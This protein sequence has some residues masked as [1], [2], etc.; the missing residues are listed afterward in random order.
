VHW[1]EISK[2]PLEGGYPVYDVTSSGITQEWDKVEPNDNRVGE[3]FQPNNA[4]IIEIDWDQQ[5]PLIQ[6]KIID[7]NG[8]EV[9][10]HEVRLLSGLQF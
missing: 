6:L 2:Q 10:Q 1:A 5:D 9:L 3:A 7:V 8:Q 4:G